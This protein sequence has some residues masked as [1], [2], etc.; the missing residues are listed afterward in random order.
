M[1]K[2]FTDTD[3]WRKIWFRKLSPKHK[4]FWE[5][6]RD[7]CDNA[8]IWEVDFELASFQIGCE[9]DQQEIKEVFK[10]QFIELNSVKWFLTDFIEWQYNCSIKELNPKNN[11]HLSVIRAL[12]KY[13]I[14]G[15]V[16]GSIRAQNAPMV[17]EGEEEEEEDKDKSSNKGDCKGIFSY[18]NNGVGIK[19]LVLDDKIKVQIN[20][21][22]K[23]YTLGQIKQGIDNYKLIRESPDYLDGSK[24][25]LIQFLRQSNGLAVFLDLESVKDR[26]KQKNK[27]G[28]L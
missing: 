25:S 28:L 14:K 9:L 13:K 5:Y 11:A 19:H 16:R 18:W 23:N 4:C 1:P 27:G 21:T 7:N 20:N 17:V 2:R 22:L 6:L 12:E 10:K 15:L 8:G 3:K 26:Y 24:W